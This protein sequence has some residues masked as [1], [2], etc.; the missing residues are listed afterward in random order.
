MCPTASM[1][2]TRPCCHHY[3][4]LCQVL[5]SFHTKLGLQSLDDIDH[6]VH[7]DLV[8]DSL[9]HGFWLWLGPMWTQKADT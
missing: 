1:L 8:S 6:A 4:S 5:C 3:G 7:T 9:L 2:Q